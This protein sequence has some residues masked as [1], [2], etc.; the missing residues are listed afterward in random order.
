MTSQSSDDQAQRLSDSRP[1][2]PTRRLSKLAFA[3]WA[4]PEM[5]SW[6]DLSDGA[7]N[8]GWAVLSLRIQSAA[9]PTK[10][11]SRAVFGNPFLETQR[12]AVLRAVVW[13][14]A[15]DY[16]ALKNDPS[17]TP[18]FPAKFVRIPGDQLIKWVKVFDGVRTT[19]D[20]V[21]D[22]GSTEGFFRLARIEWHYTSCTFEKKWHGPLERN[23]DLEEVWLEVWREMGDVLMNATPVGD[24]QESYPTILSSIAYDLDSYSPIA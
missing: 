12:E 4:G 1:E 9:R 19:I 5:V 13:D 14:S 10:L 11:E 21:Q 3:S 23:R 8:S 17:T 2:T 18:R 20:I 6:Y 15:P 22:S 7:V 16:V 24:Y